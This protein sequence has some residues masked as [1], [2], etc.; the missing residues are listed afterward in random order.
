MVVAKYPTT[1]LSFLLGFCRFLVGSL[2]CFLLFF[3]CIFYQKDDIP[4]KT[5]Q[6]T[7][8]NFCCLMRGG[9]VLF[10]M[11][12]GGFSAFNHEEGVQYSPN[13]KALSHLSFCFRVFLMSFSFWRKNHGNSLKFPKITQAINANQKSNFQKEKTHE[14]SINIK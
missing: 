5:Q 4:L 8:W 3:L 14:N 12:W 11:R 6:P 9:S 2:C 13:K 10:I 7:T 1:T